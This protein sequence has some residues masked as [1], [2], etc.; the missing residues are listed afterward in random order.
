MNKKIEKFSQNYPN[1]VKQGIIHYPIDDSIL[2]KTFKVHS[3][4][5][6]QFPPLH[7]LDFPE[8][9]SE[10]L[11]SICDF[12]WKFKDF[13]RS[14]GFNCEDL[15]RSLSKKKED[16]LFKSIHLA[17]LKPLANIMLKNEGFRKSSSFRFF[18]YKVKKIISVEMILK[19]TYLHF[20][21]YL[22]AIDLWQ[23]LIED[24]DKEMKIFF[25][26]FEIS[27]Y[28][29]LSPGQKA[30]V[31]NLIITILL[32]T[33][34]MNEECLQRHE[35]Q[36]QLR[37][38]LSEFLKNTKNVEN[39]E[40]SYVKIE[41]IKNQL[42][43]VSIRTGRLGLDR[44]FNQYFYFEW[45]SKLFVKL[46]A[47]DS[48]NWAFYH[49]RQEVKQ[50]I[51]SLCLKGIR[52][53][54]LIDK[55]EEL[56][57]DEGVLDDLNDV[58]M[59]EID[60]KTFQISQ[61]SEII[62]V[63]TNSYKLISE[64]FNIPLISSLDFLENQDISELSSQI[65]NFPQNFNSKK[66]PQKILEKIQ[67]LWDSSELH[68]HWLKALKESTQINDLIFCTSFLFTQVETFC[69][70]NKPK[71]IS[72]Y[73]NARSSYKLERLRKFRKTLKR[74]EDECYLCEDFGVVICCDLCS[75]VAH[76]HCLGLESVPAGDWKCPSCQEDQEN[77]RIT[78]SKS[79]ISNFQ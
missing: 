46:E 28:F 33:R 12:C 32:E 30:K 27:E 5:R 11:I 73:E 68:H 26:H 76:L 24:F 37:K 29:T 55:L 20:I 40:E 22:F 61:K 2:W 63:L 4:Q 38:D 60:E 59:E 57:E 70:Q 10:D 66:N 41:E 71:T 53:G 52:E 21:E 8:E 51:E 6:I 19:Q 9:I 62:Q 74:N 17:L 79:Q 56:L 36:L 58:E 43:K 42:K 16:N 39:E 47:L 54:D 31:L 1:L 34:E 77:I 67:S 44:D 15:Y 50:L 18:L 49:T 35:S 14:P 7:F 45:D 69:I 75:K 64:T 48:Q 25:K 13:L 78:R 72:S 23:D 65:L 3:I